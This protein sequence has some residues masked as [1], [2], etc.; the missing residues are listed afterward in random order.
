[1]RSVL[2]FD[3]FEEVVEDFGRCLK[4]GGSLFLYGCNF[5]SCDTSV[6]NQFEVVLEADLEQV[7]HPFTFGPD[8]RFLTGERYR[9]V[10]F[11]KARTFRNKGAVL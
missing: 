6:S 8:N 9:C 2:A 11:R 10:G 5:R 7:D 1:M 3:E 4:P